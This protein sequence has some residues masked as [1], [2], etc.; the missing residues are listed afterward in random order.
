[1]I[2]VFL[3]KS[4][5]LSTVLIDWGWTFIRQWEGLRLV[6]VFQAQPFT[7]LHTWQVGFSTWGFSKEVEGA[8][9]S[10]LRNWKVLHCFRDLHLR[11]H[12]SQNSDSCLSFWQWLFVS[13]TLQDVGKFVFPGIYWL[14]LTF[15]LHSEYKEFPLLNSVVWNSLRQ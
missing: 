1:M 14:I 2:G 7:V 12:I 4:K 15:F 3:P 6:A 9:L 5:L 11:D 8:I 10:A 13:F